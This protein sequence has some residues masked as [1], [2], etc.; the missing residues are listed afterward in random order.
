MLFTHKTFLSETNKPCPHPCAEGLKCYS[1]TSSMA[2][3][4]PSDD[5]CNI[6]LRGYLYTRWDT[7]KPMTSG[8]YTNTG[9][10]L[11]D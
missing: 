8:D 10:S 11:Y 6:H 2:Q 5:T 9:S 7:N 1:L 4:M 3:N